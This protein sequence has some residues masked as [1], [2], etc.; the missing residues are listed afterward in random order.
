MGDEVMVS[1]IATG[2]EQPASWVQASPAKVTQFKS[3]EAQ[4]K[5]AQSSALIK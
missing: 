1:I 5:V 2:F 4:L 3:Y